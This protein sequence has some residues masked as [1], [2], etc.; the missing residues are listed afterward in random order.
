M[1]NNCILKKKNTLLFIYN[2]YNDPLFKGNLFVFIENEASRPNH[3]LYLITFEQEKYKLSKEQIKTEK[4]YLAR[5]NIFWYPLTYHSGGLVLLKKI[6]DLLVSFFLVVYLRLMFNCQAIISLGTVSAG[7]SLVFSKLLAMRYYAYQFEP[8]SEFMADFGIWKKTSIS[9]KL[10]HLFEQLTERSAHIISTG[11]HA[12]MGRL[13]GSKARVY[14]LPSCVNEQK[15]KFSEQGRAEIREMQKIGDRKVFL[16]LGKFGGVYLTKEIIRL[17]SAI[18]DQDPFSF[19][20]VITPN[21]KDEIKDWFT[22]NKIPNTA[23]FLA[24]SPYAK[25][26]DYISAADF[27]IVAIP[28]LPSQKYRSPIKVGEYL[29]CGLPYLVCEGVSEDDIVAENSNVGVVVKEFSKEE[30]IR[31]YPK[32]KGFFQEDSHVLRERCRK[33]GINYRGL[34]KFRP[35]FNQILAEI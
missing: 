8:H 15:F 22:E 7:Y 5:K 23:Y 33:A 26:Q 16:Y 11:T 35:V 10:L 13:E 19:F 34:D 6:Y 25:V 30:L 1:T 28:S 21:D 20:M 18:Y 3:K 17:F 9:Y 2:S 12:M 31:V 27:G 14:L 29:C 24:E 4:T 32:I